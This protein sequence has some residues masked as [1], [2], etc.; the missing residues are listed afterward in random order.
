MA[1]GTSTLDQK[2]AAAVAFARADDVWSRALREAFGP[3]A[4]RRRYDT[5]Q[6]AHPPACR[7][8]FAARKEALRHWKQ[9]EGIT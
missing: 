1:H 2:F 5:D 3:Q 4:L 6:S 7:N 9:A 8:A